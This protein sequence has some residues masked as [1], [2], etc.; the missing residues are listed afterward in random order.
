MI[1][2]LKMSENKFIPISEVEEN[3]WINGS[4]EV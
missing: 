3:C 2:I 4:E 1:T